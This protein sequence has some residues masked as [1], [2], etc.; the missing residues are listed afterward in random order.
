MR[1]KSL[2]I[3]KDDLPNNEMDK[4][5]IFKWEVVICVPDRVNISCQMDLILTYKSTT[6]NLPKGKHE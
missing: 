2:C 1:P 6:F 5:K 3:S 4:Y